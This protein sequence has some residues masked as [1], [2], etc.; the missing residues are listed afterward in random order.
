MAAPCP[1]L[2]DG[3]ADD[4]LIHIA[5]FLPTV[6]DL[7]CLKL[8]NTRFCAKG[9]PGAQRRAGGWSQLDGAAAPECCASADEAGRLWVAGYS[10]HERGWVPRVQLE[11]WLGLMHAMEVLQV[12]AAGV[13][14]GACRG[15]AD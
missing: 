5:G 7:L 9:H 6:K 11:S 12:P 4:T 8:T 2:G 15:D 13:R 14:P 1:L 3:I 10:E